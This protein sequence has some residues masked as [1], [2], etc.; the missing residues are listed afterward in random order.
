M[1]LE[2]AAIAL[3]PFCLLLAGFGL[4]W[5]RSRLHQRGS[6]TAESG[7][8]QVLTILG[9][10]LLVL[11]FLAAIGFAANMFGLI[12]VPVA[13]VLLLG[14]LRM[15][16]NAEQQALL[17]VLTAAAERGIPLHTAAQAFAD[18]R[19]DAIGAGARDLADFLDAGVP[20]GLA[21][22]RS[23]DTMPAA[24]LLAADLGE[25]TG[26]LGAALRQAVVEIDEL[27]MTLR[28][29]LEKFF[30][31]ALVALF[32]MGMLAF[33]MIKIIP[34]FG[35]IL[36]EFEMASPNTTAWLIAVAKAG[37]SDWYITL[38]VAGV[39]LTVLVVGL[40]YYVRF[41]PRD[42]PIVRILWSRVDSALAMHWLAIGI[43]QKRPIGEVVRLLAGY[44]PRAGMRLR[45]Q[46]ALKRID[47]GANWCDSLRRVGVVRQP[48]SVVFQAAERTGNL[49]WA[50]KEMAD[51]SVQRTAYRM[52]AWLGLAF[53]LALIAVG[54]CVF[55]IALA[56]LTPLFSMVQQLA[57]T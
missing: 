4:L 23:H 17:R 16:R 2:C 29:V 12:L 36:A 6:L 51:S 42:L 53:P 38:P 45:L 3:T 54:A 46:A 11:G 26:A 1:L 15:Y 5:T 35:S 32:A 8:A 10:C 14:A 40:L 28:S 44:F 47:A 21:L 22:R 56:V 13:V 37:M 34:A 57:G 7:P 9:W 30:Y 27:E 52:R 20:L 39:L 50:L 24:A 31:L 55:L 33:L 41:S 48:E 19:D 49:V 43:E 25:R 18:E